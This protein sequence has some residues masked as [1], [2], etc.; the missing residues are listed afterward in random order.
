MVTSIFDNLYVSFSIRIGKIDP[1]YYIL[2]FQI[3]PVV[4]LDL[5]FFHANLFYVFHLMIS[6]ESPLKP[7]NTLDFFLLLN[8][9]TKVHSTLSNYCV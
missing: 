2:T 6:I 3:S 9:V 4:A 8:A 1:L 7:V 5:Y